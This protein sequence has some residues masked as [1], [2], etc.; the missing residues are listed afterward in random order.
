MT[1]QCKGTVWCVGWEGWTPHTGQSPV[2]TPHS[3]W[4][5]G[6]GTRSEA[7]VGP[8]RLFL[9]EDASRPVS[10]AMHTRDD[11]KWPS[12]ELELKFGSKGTPEAKL[13]LAGS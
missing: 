4:G 1:Q 6:P 13:L 2:P 5:A 3:A 9:P 11:V 10:V 8:Q 12:E 7:P